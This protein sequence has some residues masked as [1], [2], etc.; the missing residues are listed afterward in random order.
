MWGTWFIVTLAGIGVVLL[1]VA[2]AFGTAGLVFGALI[3]VLIGVVLAVTA[4]FRR[5]REYVER[6][7]P[8]AGSP[9]RT[10]SGG[11]PASGEG[12]GSPSSSTGAPPT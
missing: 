10:R 2:L 4:G 7:E 8:G 12:S 1:V 11:A 9:E 6:D 3:A 5:S